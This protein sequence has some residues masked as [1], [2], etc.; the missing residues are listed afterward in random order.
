M[1][2]LHLEC[3]GCAMRC[4]PLNTDKHFGHSRCTFH[5]A[6]TGRVFWEPDACEVCLAI[7]KNWSKMEPTIRYAQMGA[8]KGMLEFSKKKINNR[9]PDRHWDY[10][11][12]MNHKWRRHNFNIAEEPIKVDTDEQKTVHPQSHLSVN[13]VE[14]Q[15]SVDDDVLI[16]ESGQESFDE[17]EYESDDDDLR[18]TV[19]QVDSLNHILKDVCTELHC[20][21]NGLSAQCNNPVHTPL[22]CAPHSISTPHKVHQQPLVVPNINT[23]H[24]VHQHPL[25]VHN[26]QP[27]AVQPMQGHS[28]AVMQPYVEQIARASYIDFITMETWYR[29]NPAIHTMVGGNRIKIKDVCRHTNLP[30]EKVVTVKFQSSTREYFMLMKNLKAD[31]VWIANSASFSAI[32]TTLGLNPSTSPLLSETNYLDSYIDEDSGLRKALQELLRLSPDLTRLLAS[33]TLEATTTY[34]EENSKLFNIHSFI[35]FTAGFELTN[36]AFDRFLQDKILS[37]F[38]FEKQIGAAHETFEIK[39]EFASHEKQTRKQMLHTMSTVH[40]MEQFVGNIE[41]VDENER[42][43]ARVNVKTGQAIN[44][45]MLVEM[46]T[47][48]LRWMHAKMVIRLSL[49]TNPKNV[50]AIQLANSTLWDPDIFSDEEM[51]KVTSLAIK[52]S[53]SVMSIAQIQGNKN[54]DSGNRQQQQ[55]QYAI[56]A[57][58]SQEPASK[59]PRYSPQPSTSNSQ[60]QQVYYTK[61][62]NRGGKKHNRN[63]QNNHNNGKGKQQQQGKP[64]NQKGNNKGNSFPKKKG[65][66]NK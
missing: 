3:D 35:N 58:A 40:M 20:V 30:I 42:E 44:K 31:D 4:I 45:R 25:D 10:I 22:E 2:P 51:A 41:N 46:K 5:R 26:I 13:K 39:T 38:N 55:V 33:N 57:P 56:T 8:F 16:I 15:E 52:N 65:D 63:K 9:Y 17:S 32:S 12:I 24:N 1:D 11:P 62:G 21:N 37:I 7:D 61:R 19:A 50:H 53:K 43:R 14:R 54:R 6:C 59:R 60:P 66:S 18:S 29:F 23:P 49:L 34:F 36:K 48:T 47:N 64:K 28:Q 27:Q